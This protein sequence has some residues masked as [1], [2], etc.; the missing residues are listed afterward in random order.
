M[1]NINGY[2]ISLSPTRLSLV[3]ARRGR[4]VQAE[5]V[6]LSADRWN[7]CWNDGLMALDQPLR[8]LRL[9]FRSGGRAS[10][11]ILYQSPTLTKQI[12]PFDQG[13][14][15]ARDATR[16]KIRETVG[17]SDPVA[18]HTLAGDRAGSG[19]CMMLAYSD[20]DKTLRSLYAWLKRNGFTPGA[21]IPMSVASTI[22]AS[23][24]AMQCDDQ[25][26]ILYLDADSSVIALS[27]QGK[28]ALV[29]PSNLGYQKLIDA[30]QRAFDEHLSDAENDG[31]DANTPGE[32]AP[33]PASCLFE[34]GVPFQP[35]EYHGIDLR[36]TVLP[37]MAP[38]LQRLGIDIK[39]SIRFGLENAQGIRNLY[40][41]GT[42]AAIPGLPKAI[43]EHLEMHVQPAPGTERY[44]PAQT[45]GAGSVE[46]YLIEHGVPTQGLLPRVAQEDQT[47]RTMSRTLV[48][49]VGLATLVMAGQY[50]YATR[51]ISSSEQLMLEQ[52]PMLE[53][54]T[55][56]SDQRTRAHESAL[57]LSKLAELVSEQHDSTPQ[58]VGPLGTLATA[59]P[60]GVR[61][62]EIRADEQGGQRSIKVSGYAVA[63]QAT[64]PEQNLDQLVELFAQSTQVEAVKLG[65]TERIG[66]PSEPPADDQ[67]SQWGLQFE[68]Q[69]FVRS[70]PSPY[71]TLVK[72]GV[73]PE[74]W[75]EP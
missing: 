48:A 39:Q 30:Y 67:Q 25:T 6:T 21:M 60:D 50:M 54:V 9:R 24:D 64:G 7:D 43:A 27:R 71:S 46:R 4:V 65:A 15:N 58:W 47:Q 19:A 35:I 56:F 52:A 26:A 61:I 22:C 66:L 29:R 57:I 36:S 23:E 68:L 12:Y 53:R 51:L 72:S 59:K 13:G 32:T 55:A 62:L 74:E 45:A 31:R 44:E 20:C 73:Q 1:S 33:D 75:I 11:T 3:L 38:V 49:G 69:V 40:L 42:G 5:S 70:S 17:M 28:L 8:Q 41:Y 34:H 10:A 14:A 2:I 18:V 16:A 37:C 63:G